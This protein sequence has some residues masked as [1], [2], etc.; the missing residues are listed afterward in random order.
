MVAI[1]AVYLAYLLATRGRQGLKMPDMGS[2]DAEL[3]PAVA[4]VKDVTP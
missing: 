1:G 3:D 2:I 4:E